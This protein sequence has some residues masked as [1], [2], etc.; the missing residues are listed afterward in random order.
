MFHYLPEIDRT[1][2]DMKYFLRRTNRSI[3]GI[4]VNIT[5]DMVYGI[6]VPPLGPDIDAKAIIIGRA[7]CERVSTIPKRRSFQIH[8]IWNNA[9][10][11]VGATDCGRKI[12]RYDFRG[13]HPSS[14]A[15]SSISFGIVV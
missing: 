1:I 7:F 8:V 4:E 10:T 6:T 3:V 2:P 14:F 5:P 15:A 12:Y 9:T 11:A 13:P